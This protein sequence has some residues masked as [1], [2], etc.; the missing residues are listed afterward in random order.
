MIALNR[1]ESHQIT[2]NEI[3]THIQTTTTRDPSHV[4][5]TRDVGS[6]LSL[7]RSISKSSISKSSIRFAWGDVKMLRPK[8]ELRRIH[9]HLY[10]FFDLWH[11]R[12]PRLIS[13][14]MLNK[15]NTHPLYWFPSNAAAR[16]FRRSSVKNVTSIPFYMIS[17]LILH[18][19]V[20]VKKNHVRKSLL[21]QFE[22]W[23]KPVP[24]VTVGR[25]VVR[26]V[27]IEA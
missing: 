14:A 16:A 13:M 1:T 18:F 5:Q 9:A 26:S 12:T 21:M 23:A 15:Q 2:S 8:D 10:T 24:L 17:V 25:W 19:G 4:V 3:T 11:G 6:G 20:K 22:W 27:G 7:E